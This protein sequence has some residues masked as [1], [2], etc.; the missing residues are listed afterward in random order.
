M[1]GS[2]RLETVVLTAE[3]KHLPLWQNPARIRH[4]LKRMN[5]T[6]TLA[7]IAL[8]IPTGIFGA[9]APPGISQF[10]VTCPTSRVLPILDRAYHE[11]SNGFVN[12]SCER[13][14]DS[15]WQLL[16]EYD[17][18]RPF[19]ATPDKNYVVPAIWLAGDGAMED[20]VRLL[21]RLASSKD[22][23]LSL[24]HYRSA[25]LAAK[26]L[27]GSKAFQRTLDGALAEEYLVRS[28]SVERDLSK[29]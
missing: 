5:L 22:R 19:D 21:W 28:R 29:K 6:R 12:G 2:R 8:V 24:S 23:V 14:V 18:Q 13:F 25:I 27:F 26:E 10:N 4:A 16:P 9:E 20:Y 15:F 11:C 7:F 1:F 17:C 3:V